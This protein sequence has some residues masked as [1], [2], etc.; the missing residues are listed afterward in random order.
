MVFQ[1][2]ALYPHLTRAKNIEFPLR[3]REV[4]QGG[5]RRAGR[6]GRPDDP[7]ARPSCST[8]SRPALRRPAPAGG[9]RAG[10]RPR[11]ARLPD[12][13]AALE[14]R[15]RCCASRPGPTSSSIQRRLRHDGALRDPR[16]GRGHDD[17]APHRGHERRAASSRSARPTSSTSAPSTPSWPRFLGNPGMCLAS[18]DV[19]GGAGSSLGDMSLPEVARARRAGHRRGAA[20]VARRS[21]PRGSRRSPRSSRC[22]APTRS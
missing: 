11:A 21:A 12:G 10:H 8:A 17:G 6:A 19:T 20:R 18:G 16:P 7:A 5:A 2:Y 4:R 13:R 3:Q 9:A 15:R 22:S 1:S 14:P